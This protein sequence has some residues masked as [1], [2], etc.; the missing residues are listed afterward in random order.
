MLVL[1]PVGQVLATDTAPL[2]GHSAITLQYLPSSDYETV[3]GMG[4]Y[5]FRH[6]SPGFYFNG[7]VTT[8]TT[9]DRDDFYRNLSTTSFGHRVTDTISDFATL[10]A[11]VTFAASDSLGLYLGLGYATVTGYAEMFDPQHILDF[12]GDY[13]VPEPTPD[14]EGVN[15]NA[16]LLLRF[17]NVSAELGYHSFL[18]RAYVGFGFGF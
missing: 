10:N 1:L 2:P 5:S 6:P 7:Q 3:V 14:D 18:N 9:S 15:A 13:L 16:G 12:D 8:T 4:F 11:G 17:G